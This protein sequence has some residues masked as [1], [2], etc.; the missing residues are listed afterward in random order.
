MNRMAIGL[1]DMKN[2]KEKILV[3]YFPLADTILEGNDVEWAKK[4]FANGVTVLE[5][6]FPYEDP[7]LDGKTVTDS[8]NRAL[9]HATL[10]DVFD[11][12]KD[13]RR[14]CPDNILQIMTYFGNIEKYGI[15]SFAQ[16]CANC[17]ADAVLAPDTP[18][19]KYSELDAE[20]GKH[21]LI[22]LRF[23]VY[24]LTDKVVEDIKLNAKG[25][26]FQ[27]AVDGMTGIVEGVSDQVGNNIQHLRGAG[28]TTPI[29]AGFGI[30]SHEQIAKALA[31]GA[32]GVVVGSAIVS[33]IMQGD[34]EA[35]IASLR[36]ALREEE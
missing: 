31:M 25:Y 7:V 2:R 27:Q 20:L 24:N 6:G 19:E 10:D 14:E 21:G 18:R 8:M 17:G 23:S 12:I 35:Y 9:S 16:H 4:Y 34:G 30:S 28:V 5:M 32:D 26:I 36:A 33:H 22:F 3:G 13:I 11:I 15:A 1:A 29:I